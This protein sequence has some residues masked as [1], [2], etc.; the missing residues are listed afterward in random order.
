MTEENQNQI[1]EIKD[2]NNNTIKRINIS[3]VNKNLDNIYNNITNTTNNIATPIKLMNI[4]QEK[5]KK[6]EKILIEDIEVY[7]PYKP[8]EKQITYMKSI[9]Q[10]LNKKYL[11]EDNDFNALAALESPTGTGKTLCLLCS[12]LAWVNT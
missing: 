6:Q 9:I 3:E 11:S 12:L 2:F 1:I 10:T 5:L 4:N 8:Y 7:F